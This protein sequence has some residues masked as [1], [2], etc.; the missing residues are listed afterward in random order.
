MRLFPKYV[1]WNIDPRLYSPRKTS[2]SSNGRLWAF[3]SYLRFPVYLGIAKQTP[4][5][6]E[7]VP[8]ESW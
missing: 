2:L 5:G 3:I 4:L 8:L 6:K 1:P 7:A